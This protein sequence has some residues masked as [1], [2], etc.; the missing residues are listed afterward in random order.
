MHIAASARRKNSQGHCRAGKSIFS[1]ALRLDEH[2][3]KTHAEDVTKHP[4][5][6]I[7]L[8]SYVFPSIHASADQ[9]EEERVQLEVTGGLRGNVGVQEGQKYDQTE[10]EMPVDYLELRRYRAQI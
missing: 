5:V 1:A 7:Q 10:R 2:Y 3:V 9:N 4:Q 8:E 6:S